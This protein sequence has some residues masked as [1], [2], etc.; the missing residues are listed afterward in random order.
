MII[1]DLDGTLFN[2]ASAFIPACEDF[3][4]T[5]NKPYPGNR[6]VMK[7]VGEPEAYFR[8]WLI[9]HDIDQPFEQTRRRMIELEVGYIYKNGALFEGVKLLL[10]ELYRSGQEIALCSNAVDAYQEAVFEKTEI[11]SFFSSVRLPRSPSDN[12]T[13]MVRELIQQA[14]PASYHIVAGD[15]I[16]DIMAARDNG[17]ISIGCAYGYG[18]DEIKEADYVAQSAS[19]IKTIIDQ[20]FSAR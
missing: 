17:L 15:R 18:F 6:E 7:L 11:S 4:L 2:T 8:E 10:E 1:F 14:E 13:S 16:H 3:F 20:V 5:Y 19:E 12:K 9:R